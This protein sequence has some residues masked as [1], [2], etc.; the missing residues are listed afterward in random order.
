MARDVPRHATQSV[1]G[2]HT[3]LSRAI[4]GVRQ[5]CAMCG[6]SHFLFHLCL[7][8]VWQKLAFLYC[9]GGHHSLIR[10]LSI[11][12]KELNINIVLKQRANM[13]GAK[14]CLKS[15]KNL[16]VEQI[17]GVFALFNQMMEFSLD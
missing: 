5:P 11:P 2:K 9:R 12:N 15:I 7:I 4:I 8:F 3:Q 14:F 10:G 6:R 13:R 1:L 17:L 16:L